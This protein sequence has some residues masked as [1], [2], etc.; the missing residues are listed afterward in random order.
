[1]DELLVKGVRP[2]GGSLCDMR[3][4]DGRIAEIGP[5]LATTANTEAVNAHGSI[6]I[7]GFVNAHTH[8]YSGLAPLGMPAPAPPPENFVQILERIWWRLDRAIDEAKQQGVHG[9]ALTP[10]LLERMEQ[11]SG[12]DSLA[13]N[14]ALALNNARL[15]AEV[16]V[17]LAKLKPWSVDHG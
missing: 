5:D 15:G 17:A 1:M 7:P 9:K 10:W 14:V 8:L 11:L 4:R 13:A 16:A 6:V 12:G 2:H 3:I